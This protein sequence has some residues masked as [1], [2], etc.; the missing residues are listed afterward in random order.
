MRD[1]GGEG[2][3]TFTRRHW[4]AACVVAACWTF[5]G[6]LFTPQTYL[7]NLRAPVPLTPARALAATLALFYVWAVL[8]PLVLWLGR[9]FPLE[10]H[11]LLRNLCL[12]VALGGVLALAHMVLLRGVNALL[13]S[14][15]ASYQPPAPLWTMAIG[16]GATNVLLYW[17]V[18]AAGHAFDYFRKYRERE[19]TLTRAQLQAL[20]LQLHPHF[21]FNTLNAIAELVHSD[22]HAADRAIL[23]LSE[24]LRFSLASEKS[25][26]VTLKEE[27]E[28]L[29]KYAE[30]QKTLMG[31][32]LRLSVNAEPGVL[33]ACVPNMLLQPL[34]EN[35][36]KHGIS[37]RR[38]GGSVSVAA[39][40]RGP[41]LCLEVSDD[42]QGLTAAGGEAGGVG[43]INTR[44]R[45][46]HL[47]G[48]DH[49]F[50]LSSPPGQGVTILITI[51]FREAGADGHDTSADY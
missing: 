44:E 47:Y 41:C 7:A 49:A 22:P 8:T 38:A 19:F 27:L 23:R 43:L 34:V 24:L 30:I 26:E 37:P 15:A 18:I 10:H 3:I 46:R 36:I 13:D 5:L 31:D 32:R 51:P 39:R 28:F 1:N 48:R 21:L 33:D 45:L 16:L 25:Q 42:G 14:V 11:R 20:K 4:K 50:E 35:S 29:L 40:R 9:R 17:G 12:H 6:L 2:V